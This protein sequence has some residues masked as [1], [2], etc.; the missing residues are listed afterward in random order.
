MPIYFIGKV[1]H[2]RTVVF[3]VLHQNTDELMAIPGVVGTGQGRCG[4]RDCIHVYVA[5]LTPELEAKVPNLLDGYPV[6]VRVMGE[7]R[8]LPPE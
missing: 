7:P 6:E 5:E 2:F 3:K 1:L 8:A 4:G